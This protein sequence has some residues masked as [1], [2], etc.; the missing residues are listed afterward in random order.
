[1][2]DQNSRRQPAQAPA[3]RKGARRT[4]T[5][6]V[7]AT[8]ALAT[9]DDPDRPGTLGAKHAAL[10][11]RPK[12]R[13]ADYLR[14]TTDPAVPPTNNP[15]EQEIRMVNIKQ[16]ASGCMRTTDGANAF[17]AI[18]SYLS[19]ARKHSITPLRAL[20]SLGSDNIWLPVTP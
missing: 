13:L 1:M 20:A 7:K 18:R 14:F 8:Q 11:R 16:K 3:Q 19:T 12:D 6:L 9:A 17:A 5:E 4:P 10:R 15:A 2:G